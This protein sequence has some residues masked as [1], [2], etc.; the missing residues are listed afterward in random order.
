MLFSVIACALNNEPKFLRQSWLNAVLNYQTTDGCFSL[1][2]KDNFPVE[3]HKPI[4]QKWRLERT[5]FD[6]FYGACNTHISAMAAGAISI[7]VRY[8]LDVYY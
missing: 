1:L 7:G 8:I 6:M 4:T 5:R 3:K 2:E